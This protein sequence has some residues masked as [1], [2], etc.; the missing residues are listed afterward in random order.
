MFHGLHLL[1]CRLSWQTETSTKLAE[2]STPNYPAGIHAYKECSD[3]GLCDTET[4]RCLCFAG[5]EGFDCGRASCP[6]D[7][8][9]HGKCV[10]DAEV[11][12]TNY[13]NNGLLQYQKQYWNAYK[14]QQCVCDRGWWG[15]DCSL[16]MCPEGESQS[17][18]DPADYINDVQMVTLTFAD[19]ENTSPGDVEQFFSLT[20]T[21]MFHGKFTT[22]PISYWDDV[23]VAQEAL[24]S[25]PNFVLQDVEVNKVSPLYDASADDPPVCTTAYNTYFQDV[26]CSTDADCDTKFPAATGTNAPFAIFCDPQLLKCVETS[27]SDACLYVD[28]RTEFD[29]GCASSFQVDGMYVDSAGRRIWGRQTTPAERTC[30][31]GSFSPTESFYASACSDESDC[32]A[33]STMSAVTV[34]ACNGVTNKCSATTEWDEFIDTVATSN[35]NVVSFLVNFISTATPGQQQLLECN[36]GT[37]DFSGAFP[38]YPSSLLT[39]DVTRVSRNVWTS[40]GTEQRLCFDSDAS[41]YSASFVATDD[42]TA[43]LGCEANF[44][45][46]ELQEKSKLESYK[47][48]PTDSSG[49]VFRNVNNG[50][51]ADTEIGEDVVFHTSTPCSSQGDCDVM[52]GEC[53]CMSGFSGVACEVPDVDLFV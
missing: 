8:S 20:F 12:S 11:D 21:D 35:C 38:R 52:T 4:G 25:L 42:E 31:I 5:Y 7:C 53:S 1:R 15:N 33:C 46:T 49:T 13:Y 47:W 10:L 44:T 39:C 22:K 14:T 37:T 16:R 34:G 51:F 40:E 2:A 36:V 6:E 48:Y 9:G 17:G 28:G 19:L 29:N 30:Q 43:L 3:R 32:T 27:P 50:V 26:S 18:C 24:N 45:I 41:G 23:A